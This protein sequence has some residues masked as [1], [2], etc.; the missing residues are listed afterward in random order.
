[1][2]AQKTL[3]E[4]AV[5]LEA[6]ASGQAMPPQPQYGICSNLLENFLEL[7]SIALVTVAACT[8]PECSG[9]PKFPVPHP[10]YSPKGAYC[11][12]KWTGPYG[13]SRRRLCQHIADWIRANLESA[14]LELL[15][16]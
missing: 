1:M 5:L 15:L 2:D 13:A 4:V 7:N 11:S 10:V 8:W 12:A 6:W 3:N 9:D 16:D 14:E